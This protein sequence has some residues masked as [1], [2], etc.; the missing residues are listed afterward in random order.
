MSSRAMRQVGSAAMRVAAATGVSVCL[1]LWALPDQAWPNPFAGPAPDEPTS[2]APLFPE[3]VWAYIEIEDAGELAANYPESKLAGMLENEPLL[4]AYR[5]SKPWAQLQ[6]GLAFVQALSGVSPAELARNLLGERIAAGFTTAAGD[7]SEPGLLVV[8]QT[9]DEDHAEM[10]L[11]LIQGLAQSDGGGRVEVGKHRG[12]EGFSIDKK[13][14]LAA[15]GARVIGASQNELLKAAVDR[16]LDGSKGFAA[17]DRHRRIAAELDGD[18]R[19]SFEVDLDRVRALNPEGRLG[20]EKLDEAFPSLLFQDVIEIMNLSPSVRGCVRLDREEFALEVELPTQGVAVPERL[21]FFAMEDAQQGGL[22]ALS[23]SQTFTTISG[24]RDLARFW[25]DR[26]KLLT[27][28]TEKG[29]AEF[30]S[31]LGIFFSGKSIPDEILPML[32][33]DWVIVGARQTF[34]SGPTPPKVRFP[35]GAAVLHAR[36]PK[37]L[38]EELSVALQSLLAILNIQRGEQGQTPMRLFVELRD[39]NTV[40]GGRFLENDGRPYDSARFN[41]S[42]AITLVGDRV[43]LS[44]SEELLDDIVATLKAEGGAPKSPPGTLTRLHLRVDPGIELVRENRDALVAQSVVDDG[45]TFEEAGY[46]FDLLTLAAAQVAELELATRIDQD[47][48]RLQLT[49]EWNDGAP[50]SRA[51]AAESTGASEGE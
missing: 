12:V 40:Y 43:V 29:F 47:A 50:L 8:V 30:E 15:V 21:A 46:E 27:E 4:A 14:F 3:D 26:D 45:K 1:A 13:M 2:I 22:L 31:G 49:L 44:T 41:F 34:S 48:F 28:E 25:E 7:S 11:R 33:P 39:G 10:L 51:T 38:F 24:W 9:Q 18:A 36:D 16:A 37:V 19:V 20:A 23:G 42:P 32:Y 5:D 35:C 17:T 6:A